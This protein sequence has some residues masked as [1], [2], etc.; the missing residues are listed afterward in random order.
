MNAYIH[1]SISGMKVTQS[2]TREDVNQKVFLKLMD[3]YQDK[4]MESRLYIAYIFPIVKNIQI[5]SQGV[6]LIFAL[7]VMKESVSAGVIVAFL[8][9]VGS[10]WM[11][12][13]NISEFYNQLVAASAYL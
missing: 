13:L 5:T 4:W 3:E 7:Y 6:M 8:G 10:F 9:Y 12:L 11:P 1:E 2:F